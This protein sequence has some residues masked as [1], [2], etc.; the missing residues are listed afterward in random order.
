MLILKT[1]PDQRSSLSERIHADMSDI[2]QLLENDVTPEWTAT[3][4]QWEDIS[5]LRWCSEHVLF[6]LFSMSFPVF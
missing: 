6:V 3:A 2:L 5:I 4:R 1:N